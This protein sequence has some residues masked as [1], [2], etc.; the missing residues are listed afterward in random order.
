[1]TLINSKSLRFYQGSYPILQLHQGLNQRFARHQQLPLALLVGQQS[2]ALACDA[3]GSIHKAGQGRASGYTPYGYC[4]GT[5]NSPLAYTGEWLEPFIDGYLLGNGYRAYNTHLMRFHSPDNLSPF[6]AGG[7]N[8]Y[9][10]CEG[11]PVNRSDPSGHK[12]GPPSSP[13]LPASSPQLHIS[14][15][16]FP[17]STQVSATPGKVPIGTR[18]LQGSSPVGKTSNS[19]PAMDAIHEQRIDH[20]LALQKFQKEQYAQELHKYGKDT[21]PLDL[22]KD[23]KQQLSLADQSVE[24]INKL[25]AS[26][27]TTSTE[28]AHG[29]TSAVPSPQVS[30][31]RQPDKNEQGGRNH[32]DG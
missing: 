6:G 9:G 19:T 14:Y 4:P 16:T 22:T 18:P 5:G 11:D 32:T 30:R 2:A 21:H 28:K 26:R 10:Y 17:R 20:E 29:P 8:S 1:M 7:L 13:L 3:Q 24:Q 15:G 12:P 27:S 25:I 23:F 31:V